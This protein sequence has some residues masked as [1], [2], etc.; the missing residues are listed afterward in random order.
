[1]IG[2]LVVAGYLRVHRTLTDHSTRDERQEL[3][4]RTLRGLQAL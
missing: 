1:L 4:G 2:D 3:I